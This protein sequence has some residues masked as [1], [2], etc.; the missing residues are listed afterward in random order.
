MTTA[1][2][3]LLLDTHLWIWLNEGAPA[4]S[5]AVIRRIDRAAARGQA[6]VSIMSVWEVGLLDAKGPVVLGLDLPTWVARALAPP[7]TLA[8]LTPS[9]ALECHRL[10]GDLHGD[11]VDRILVATARV[12]RLTLLTRDRALLDY[13]AKG[14]LRAL[15]G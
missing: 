8:P 7:I 4:L 3:R 10:P 2:E 14:H 13:A 12:E 11:P 6:F 9:I 5:P 15:A 1:T